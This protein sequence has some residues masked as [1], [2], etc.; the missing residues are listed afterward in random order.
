MS[1][2]PIDMDLS[3]EEREALRGVLNEFRQFL[4]GDDW[5]QDAK[6]EAKRRVGERRQ[7]SLREQYEQE[8]ADI[9]HVEGR[10]RLRDEYRKR[11]LEI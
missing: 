8:V 1:E 7:A 5:V 3:D 6:R 9:E 2:Q 11:G 4:A 10:L